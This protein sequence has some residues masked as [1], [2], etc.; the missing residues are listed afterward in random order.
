MNKKIVRLAYDSVP[1]SILSAALGIVLLAWPSL[2]SR[3]ICYGLGIGI[4]LAGASLLMESISQVVFSILT[5]RSRKGY[6][7]HKSGEGQT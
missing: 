2:S 6:L 3:M 1:G 4:L 7:S 5:S